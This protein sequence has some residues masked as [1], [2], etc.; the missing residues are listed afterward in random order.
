MDTQTLILINTYR[1]LN[2][3]IKCLSEDDYERK[4]TTIK[5]LMSIL[6]SVLIL[7]HLIAN[8]IYIKL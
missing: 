3:Y 5:L 4:F 7:V 6:M 2:T 8:V 1:A